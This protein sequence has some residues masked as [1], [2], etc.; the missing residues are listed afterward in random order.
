M[1]QIYIIK[2]D[3]NSEMYGEIKKKNFFIIVKSI[4]H[5]NLL[6]LIRLYLVVLRSLPNLK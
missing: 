3:I 6:Q 2:L 5:F 1:T 4:F